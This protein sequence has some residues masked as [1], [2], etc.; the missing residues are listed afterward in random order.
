MDH[1]TNFLKKVITSI[2]DIKVFSKYAK[3]GFFRSIS[4]AML[5]TLILAIIRSAFAV[6]RNNNFELNFFTST[7]ITNFGM[8]FLNLLFDC[9]IVSVVSSLFAIFMRMVVKH[10]ALYSLTLYAATLPLMVQIIL[11][12]FNPNMSFDTMFIVGTLTY[13]ILILKYIKDE[14]IKKLT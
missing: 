14:I 12:I 4:Y 13:V 6:Y 5:L 7:I 2:Y 9:L 1:R 3:E 8:S 10:I 11:E